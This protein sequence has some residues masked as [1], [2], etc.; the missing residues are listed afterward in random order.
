MPVFTE[1][2]KLKPDIDMQWRKKTRSF[3]SNKKISEKE[4]IQT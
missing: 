3:T 1:E 2:Q 4:L